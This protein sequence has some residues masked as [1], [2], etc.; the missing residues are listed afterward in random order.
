MKRI[1][2]AALASGLALVPVAY[3]NDS[4][5][6][7][8]AMAGAATQAQLPMEQTAKHMQKNVSRMHAQIDGIEQ[9][10]DPAQR[11]KLLAEHMQTMREN[12]ALGQTLMPGGAMGMMGGQGGMGMHGSQG[13]MGTMDAQPCTGKMGVQAG[14]AGTDLSAHVA[15]MEKRMDAMQAMMSQMSARTSPPTAK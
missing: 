6:A 15:Q 12:M 5:H 14:V 3:A 9:A 11:E 7:D 2:I 4:H 10:K 13:G 8:K 1:L